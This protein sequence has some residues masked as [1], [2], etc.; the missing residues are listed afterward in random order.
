MQCPITPALLFVLLMSNSLYLTLRKQI[1]IQKLDKVTGSVVSQFRL[2]S[3]A[4]Y[5]ASHVAFFPQSN[6]HFYSHQ[7]NQYKPK[8][9]FLHR[10]KRWS[11][12]KRRRF[13]HI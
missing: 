13:T 7:P 4:I 11:N 10:L 2:A 3:I 1:T 5:L 12:I 6:I 8:Y 9:N